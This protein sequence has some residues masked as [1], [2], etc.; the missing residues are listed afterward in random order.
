MTKFF[1]FILAVS[2]IIF[3]CKSASKSYQKGDYTDAIERG[4][5]KLQKDPNDY[6]TRD[7]VKNSYKYTVNQHEDEIR[8]LSN[9]K[10]DSRYEKIYEEYYSLQRL[11]ETIREYPVASQL[12][13]PTDYSEYVNTYRDKAAEAHL[14]KANKWMDE[15]TKIAYREAYKEFNVALQYRPED[16]DLRKMRDTAYEAAITNVVVSEMQN[17]GGYQYGSSYQMQNFQRDVIRTL[18]YNMNNEFVK[19][20]NEFEAR[21]KNV[22]PDQIMELNLSR[23]SLGQPNDQR[24]TREVTKEVV[25]KEVVYKPDSVV[26]QYGTVRAKI[27]N[28]TRTSL[29]QGDLFITV[30]DT[31]GRIIFNDR[32][33]GEHKW[34]TDFATY[35][36]DE[37]AL[38]D[39]DRQALNN[40]N[41]STPPNED[42]IMEE[43]LKQI[44]SDLTN[45]LRSY[46]TR[47]Q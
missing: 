28:T 26:K 40:N 19:F 24:T 22:Q 36:G 21:S 6:E 33:T 25:V 45:R 32:F 43:L 29:S 11:Y 12:V 34:Q 46:Y 37:R 38:S 27:T 5:K 3:S 30:K 8:I 10:N 42:Q 31:K 47:Y 16:F 20:Y 23:I 2:V 13:K 9:S 1:T 4:V 14:A 39:S 41:N 18:S 17:M 44:Q 35:T 7:L 15:G